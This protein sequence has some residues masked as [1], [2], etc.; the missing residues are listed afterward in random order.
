[1]NARVY[2]VQASVQLDDGY[3]DVPDATNPRS[4]L[5][6]AYREGRTVASV[7]GDEFIA[8]AAGVLDPRWA[9]DRTRDQLPAEYHHLIDLAERLLT[10]AQK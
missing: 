4:V 10:E 3:P 8:D 2:S 5:V 9:F 7:F 1:M 6:T